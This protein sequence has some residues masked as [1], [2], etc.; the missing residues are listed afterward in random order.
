MN[1]FAN[2]TITGLLESSNPYSLAPREDI[3][4]RPIQSTDNAVVNLNCDSFSFSYDKVLGRWMMPYIMQTVDTRII[5]RSNA[6]SNYSYGKDLIYRELQL[7]PNVFTA[8]LSALLFP[9]GGIILF[10]SL[11]RNFVN[12]FMPKQGEGPNQDMLDNG[13]FKILL[14]GRGKC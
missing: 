1:I 3:T 10:F 2:S 12:K 5:H 4:K 8:M 9:I 14:W 7:A 11:T 6:L 13:F